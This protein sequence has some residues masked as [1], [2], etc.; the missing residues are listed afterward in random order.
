VEIDEGLGAHGVTEETMRICAERV[1]S[2]HIP[3]SVG[4]PRGFR[5]VDEALSVLK[6]AY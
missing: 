5:N 6:A 2:Q 4:G 3:R 1:F